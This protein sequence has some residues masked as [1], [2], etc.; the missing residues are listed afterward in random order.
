M[1][2]I[3]VVCILILAFFG[4]ANSAYLAQ[5]EASGEPLICNIQNFSGCNIVTSSEYSKLFGIPL[6]EYG[7]LFY[8]I[9]FVLA[10]LELVIFDR[11]L[12]RF[13]QAISLTGV[14]F[15]LYFTF[16]QIFFIGALCIYC[17]TSAAIA[18]LILVFA[19][20]IEPVRITKRRNHPPMSPPPAPPARNLRMPPIS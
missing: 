12:R 1:K 3:G 8:G 15:S 14:I 11:L 6:A 13:L 17:L 10:A 2:R 20:F 18:F 5:Q 9:L 7:V 4:L 19:S 16:V